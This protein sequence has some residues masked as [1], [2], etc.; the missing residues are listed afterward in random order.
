MIMC[1]Q[2]NK[3]S[4]DLQVTIREDMAITKDIVESASLRGGVMQRHVVVERGVD[5]TSA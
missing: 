2:R 1:I 3:N 4:S 5:S